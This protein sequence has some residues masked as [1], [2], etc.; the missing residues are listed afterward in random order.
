MSEEARGLITWLLATTITAATLVGLSV[1]FIL[2]P[3]L[4]D[5]LVDP[6]KQVKKQ[7]T[8]NH[9][10]NTVPT[11]LDRIDDVSKQVGSLGEVVA[12]HMRWS[13]EWVRRIESDVAEAKNKKG[14]F[15]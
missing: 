7:V 6:M 12:E 3:Y 11:V 8:E 14:L 9:H 15:R 10:S 13:E 4:R 1:K 2:L 5:H